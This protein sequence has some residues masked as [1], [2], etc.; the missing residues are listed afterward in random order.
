[1]PKIVH[2]RQKVVV[3]AHEK[4][5]VDSAHAMLY[6]ALIQDHSVKSDILG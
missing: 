5:T 6:K 1:M 3:P 2:Q 4:G